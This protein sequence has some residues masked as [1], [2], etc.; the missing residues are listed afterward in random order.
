MILTTDDLLK[1]TEEE[2]NAFRRKRCS[3]N[4]R[5][6]SIAEGVID[7]LVLASHSPHPPVG[8]ILTNGKEVYYQAFIDMEVF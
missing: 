5:D 3:F 8:F 1:L 2:T 7:K 6:G 4:M